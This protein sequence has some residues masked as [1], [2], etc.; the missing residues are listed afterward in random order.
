MREALREEV[1][2]REGEKEEV[3]E[4]LGD[5]ES[6]REAVPVLVPLAIAE[7]LLEGEEPADAVPLLLELQLGVAV[8]ERLP[9]AVREAV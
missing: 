3:L 2:E 1:P 9:D 4:R 5:L 6:V 7:E 8:P